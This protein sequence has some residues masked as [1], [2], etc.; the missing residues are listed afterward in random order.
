MY[1]GS[2]SLKK[3]GG[4]GPAAL[5]PLLSLHISTLS[6]YRQ[7]LDGV[8]RK[9]FSLSPIKG[10]NEKPISLVNRR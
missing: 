6:F 5:K 3:A 1:N 8:N 10:C 7:S 4:H 9:C 2:Q